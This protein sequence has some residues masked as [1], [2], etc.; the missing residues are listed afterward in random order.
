M[1]LDH[2]VP[3]FGAEFCPGLDLRPAARAFVLRAE[4]LAAFRAEFC[5]LRPRAT[6]GTQRG[7]LT[8]QVEVLGQILRSNFFFHLLDCGLRLLG[9]EFDFQVRRAV[10]AK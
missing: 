8:G 6:A 3:A 7:R 1:R 10:E 2:L 5:S 9:S 4:W